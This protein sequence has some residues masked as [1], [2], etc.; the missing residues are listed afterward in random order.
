MTVDRKEEV[1]NWI[2]RIGKTGLLLVLTILLAQT[3]GSATRPNPGLATGF[4][5]PANGASNV[6]RN[7]GTNVGLKTGMTLDFIRDDSNPILAGDSNLPITITTA[8]VVINIIPTAG[9]TSTLNCLR[10]NPNPPP[11]QCG[12]QITSGPFSGGVDNELQVVLSGF[13]DPNVNVQISVNNVRSNDGSSFSLPGTSWSFRTKTAPP[14]AGSVSLEMVFDTSGSM[15]G[16]AAPIAACGSLTRMQALK[17]ASQSIFSLFT[18]YALPGDKLGLVTFNSMATPFGVS[19]GTNLRDATNATERNAIKSNLDGQT[20]G[21]STSIGA[22]LKATQDSGFLS[23]TTTKRVFLFSDGEQNTV[24]CVGTPNTAPCASTVAMSGSLQ[25][26]GADYLSGVA[27]C[28]VTVG[29]F[30]GPAYVLQQ[31]IKTATS[32]PGPYVHAITNDPSCPRA[33]SDLTTF[34]TQSLANLLVGDKLE[35]VR[36]VIGQTVAG[37]DTTEKFFA[38]THDGSLSI[39]L[40]SPAKQLTGALTSLQFRLK[41]PDGTVIDPTPVTRFDRGMSFTTIRVPLFLNGKLIQPK[42]EWEVRLLGSMFREPVDYHL[43]VMLDNADIA[44]DYQIDIQDPGTGEPIPVRVKLTESG[45][46]VAGANVVAQLLGPENGTG[47]ILSTSRTP[48]GTPNTGGDV[49]R[50]EAEKKLLLLLEDPASASLFRN[51]SLPSLV[52]LD[53]GQAANGDTTANDGTYSG[54]FTGALQEGHYRFVINL[55][56]P[57]ATNGDFQ[58]TQLLNVYVRPKPVAANTR[59]ALLSST[60][61]VDGSVIVR[62]SATPRDRFNNFIGPDYLGHLNIRSSQGSIASPLQDNLDGSYETSYRLPSA[63]SNPDITVEVMGTD[64]VTK[65]LNALGGGGNAAFKRWGISLHAGSTFPHGSF[66]SFFNPGPS[67]GAD[68]EYR[69]TPLFSIEG[70]LGHDRF[71]NKFFS[72]TF[73]MTHLSVQPK[74]TFGT[75][76]VRPSLH[77]GVGAYFPQGGGT[78]FGGNV[79]ASLQF[80]ITPNFAVEP[81]YNYRAVNFTGST[82]KYSTLQGGVRF[83]F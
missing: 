15:G 38:N 7:I 14:R 51:K 46:S 64:V 81:S 77:F 35:N 10:G 41:A 69:F 17:D 82:V 70:Y 66:G 8:T 45:A 54:L 67:F 36:D 30:S 48:T 26:D 78:H 21:G 63:S 52:L 31:N 16:S 9:P 55:R 37:T 42:G 47:N 13:F 32:C 27:V 28:P 58:R 6:E 75:G 1:M 19:G 5:F 29:Q 56:A 44:S 18:S 50:S 59:L 61:Q 4:L 3:S 62:L 76:T 24:P 40:A 68:L 83:R 25:V 23:D 74:F 80:W 57:S 73:Y 53:N 60:R 2:H 12:F 20:P 72:N 33:T 79:G 39:L 11:G 49:I 34:F 71:R 43:I 22:G 65:P